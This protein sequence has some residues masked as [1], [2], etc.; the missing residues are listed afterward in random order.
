METIQTANETL[1]K[2]LAKPETTARELLNRQAERSDIKRVALDGT[3]L[4]YV[5]LGSGE[6]VVF[7]H[8]GFIDFTIW[9]HQLAAV[10]ER[11]RAIAYSRRY[12]WPNEGIPDGADDPMGPHA[13]DLAALIQT[14]GLGPTHLVGHS[15]GAFICMLTAHRIP[16]LVRSLTLMEQPF[17]PSCSI[18]PKLEEIAKL[19][20]TH[21]G[22]GRAFFEFG[23]K[24]AEPCL[25][26]MRRG[27]VEDGLRKFLNYMNPTLPDF[28]GTLPADA[29]LHLLAN[30]KSLAAS[31]L[32]KGIPAFGDENVRRIQHPTLLVKAA[33]TPAP[34]RRLCDR[35]RQLLPNAERTEIPDASHTMQWQNSPALNRALVGFMAKQAAK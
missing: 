1:A 28:Y 19:M 12:A 6:P 16:Q 33:C 24:G 3:Q 35:L 30:S 27:E 7:V 29:R 32:G 13:D 34:V 2:K 20:L 31:F 17:L 5:E 25:D 4:A 22:L 8:G 9:E 18:P 10:G 15:A 23:S 21:P 26:S 11:Y 14:L